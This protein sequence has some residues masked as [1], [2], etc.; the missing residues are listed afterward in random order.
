[1]VEVFNFQKVSD[2]SC[3][4]KTFHSVCSNNRKHSTTPL[5]FPKDGERDMVSHVKWRKLL[6]SRLCSVGYDLQFCTISYVHALGFSAIRRSLKCRMLHIQH[7]WKH[8][9]FWVFQVLK[10]EVQK[11]RIK[12]QLSES[13]SGGRRFE[14]Y[15]KENE[16][17]LLVSFLSQCIALEGWD[18]QYCWRHA[19][20]R[21]FPK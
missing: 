15:P 16:T 10:F 21:L 18:V 3:C 14:Q 2:S 6:H 20:P 11:K 1:M 4:V 13:G 17:F 8:S 9:L 19:E 5:L 7:F 12:L